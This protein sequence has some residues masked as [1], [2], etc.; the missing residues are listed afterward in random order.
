LQA[1]SNIGFCIRFIAF[2][3]LE[4]YIVL[5]I[6]YFIQSINRIFN[7]NATLAIS[8]N[9]KPKLKLAKS[10]LLFFWLMQIKPILDGL[11]D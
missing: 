9:P 10:Y 2:V 7:H 5:Q 4:K 1:S 8:K 3:I 11:E 6:K